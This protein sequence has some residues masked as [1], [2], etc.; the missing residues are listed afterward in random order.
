[1]QHGLGI[2]K[3]SVGAVF[4]WS[5]LLCYDEI[6]RRLARWTGLK[7]SADKDRIFDMH[8]GIENAM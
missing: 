3:A 5:G 6:W 8:G 2:W 4:Q 7:S 1:M